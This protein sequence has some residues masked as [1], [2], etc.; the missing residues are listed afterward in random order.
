M[1][2][3]VRDPKEHPDAII[4]DLSKPDP[5]ASPSRRTT[6]PSSTAASGSSATSRRSATTISRCRA[7]WDVTHQIWR[8]VL[9]RR[10]TPTGGCR[11]IP[12]TTCSARPARSATAATRSTTTSQTKTVTEWNVGCE[13]CHGPGARSRRAA[14]RARTSSIRRASI[15]CTPTTS[16]SSAIRRAS[17]CSNPIDGKYYDWPV[18]FHVGL[19]L[20]DFWKLEEHKL[21]R[22][23]VHAFRRRHRAQEPDAGQRLRAE[24]DV[25]ARRHLLQLP[26]R[27]RHGE[28]RR[29]A[30]S[31]A[32]TCCA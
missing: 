31:P 30:S 1:A 9:R 2:N 26:R 22:D 14:H 10:T 28:Q 27:A 16:A 17:R 21:G 32:A 11:T 19:N 3:V 23:D 15:R 29:S 24:R 6:S 18:G 25:H 4:P 8:A 7:Q 20:K 12:P 13:K 5:A